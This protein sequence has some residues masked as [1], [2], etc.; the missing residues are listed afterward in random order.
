MKLRCDRIDRRNF[1]AGT[2]GGALVLPRVIAQQ[3]TGVDRIKIGQ[4]GTRHAHAVGKMEALRK[5]SDLYEVVGVVEPDPRARAE[6][7]RRTPFRDLPFISEEALLNSP[8]LKAVA[9]E[10][11]VQELVPAARRCLAAGYHI[12][13]DKPA[14]L[15]MSECRALHRLAQQKQLTV[16]MGYMFRYNAGFEF[17]WKVLE[18]GW[19]GEITEVNGMIGKFAADSLRDDLAQYPG[20]GMFELG[21]HLI[22]AVVNVLG[23][24]N[25]VQPF[26]RRSRPDRD[27][28]ADNQLAVLEYSKAFATVRCNHLDP[29]GSPRRQF[30]VTGT[31]GT[32]EIRPL[33]RPKVRLAV[34]RDRGE[35]RKGY[36]DVRLPRMTGRYDGEFRDLAK[37]IR[38]EKAFGWSAEHDLVVHEC[39]LRA[40]GMAVD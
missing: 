37:V 18:E 22:D 2:I 7:Q 20:G 33:E 27:T 6:A 19:L 32:L 31:E 25:V 26:V 28:F 16:Q 15:V 23:K 4:L 17:L 3:N 30:N 38:G 9:V 29:F 11:P 39:V 1:L 5:L 24:P 36:Q 10:T 35:F 21:C 12:H 34:N 14:G 8:G 40:S 13:L